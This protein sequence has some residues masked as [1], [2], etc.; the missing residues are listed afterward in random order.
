MEIFTR[1]S[2]MMKASEMAR[3]FSSMLMDLYMR[4]ILDEEN[5]MVKED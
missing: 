1:E 4:V 2:G 5:A 3:E